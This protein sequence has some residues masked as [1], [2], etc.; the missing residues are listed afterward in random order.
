[1]AIV[2]MAFE[3]WRKDVERENPQAFRAPCEKLEPAA[4]YRLGLCRMAFAEG[5]RAERAKSA[6][7]NFMHQQVGE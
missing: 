1:M 2:D 6:L 5:R 4:A 3:E 7:P